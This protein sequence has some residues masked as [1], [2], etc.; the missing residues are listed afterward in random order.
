MAITPSLIPYKAVHLLGLVNRNQYDEFNYDDALYKE[1]SPAFTAV[2][3]GK[4]IACAGVM[5]MWAGVGHAWVALSADSSRYGVWITRTI[6][7]VMR[8]II[9]GC[10]LH[11]VEAVVYE[12]QKEDQKWIERLGFESEGVSKAFTSMQENVIRYVFLVDAPVVRVQESVDG[13][14]TC[15]MYIGNGLVGFAKHRYTAEEHYAYGTGV[16]IFDQYQGRGLAI[17]LHQAR[18]LKATRD[19]APFFVGMTSDYNQAMIRI[20][21]KCGA[22]R[23]ENQL[24]ITYVTPL[25]P[26]NV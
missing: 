10:A 16:V 20:L 3:D 25:R 1:A 21:E 24:G 4:I 5:L 23:C 8:D 19:G 9:R 6:R 18:L 26:F 7:K 2:A 14:V 17:K 13:E 11:R 22:T 15:N 12:K